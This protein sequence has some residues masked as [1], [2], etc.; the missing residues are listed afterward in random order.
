MPKAADPQLTERIAKV[1]LRLLDKR[2]P[3]AVTMRAV[4]AAARIATTTIY[5][6]FADRDAL[7][8]GVVALVQQDL[9]AAMQST[10]SVDAF[11]EAYIQFFCRYPHRYAISMQAFD[12]RMASGQSMPVLGMFKQVLAHETGLKGRELDDR[13]L[14][15]AS[16]VFG[17]LRS[18]IAAGPGSPRANELRRACLSAMRLLT[19]QSKR[20]HV[21][22]FVNSR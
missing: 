13:A 21:E 2:G 4:A 6:R 18:M 14:A 1:T 12:S 11:G 10:H 9:I 8:Q 5:E 17:T 20:T 15:F 16:L 19:A 7:L 22:A 3:K